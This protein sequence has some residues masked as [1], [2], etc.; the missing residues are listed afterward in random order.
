MMSLLLLRLRNRW[1]ERDGSGGDAERASVYVN[2]LHGVA[3]RRVALYY[4]F[5][6]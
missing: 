2:D 6:N 3:L 5:M 4:V 1:S